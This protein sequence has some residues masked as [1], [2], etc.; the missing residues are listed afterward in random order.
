MIRND[1]SL[2][3][4]GFAREISRREGR[5]ASAAT[6]P[7]SPVPLFSPFAQPEFQEALSAYP[8]SAVA[9][10]HLFRKVAVPGVCTG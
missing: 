5:I 2:R 6:S 3:L 4:A 9:S 7:F 10:P 1:S 8:E